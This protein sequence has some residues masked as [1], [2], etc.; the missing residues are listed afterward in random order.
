MRG[1]A[2]YVASALV[3]LSS[4]V[5]AVWAG[6][7]R[8][9]AALPPSLADRAGVI[10]PNDAALS[11]M[12]NERE[13]AARLVDFAS[14]ARFEMPHADETKRTL[15]A[16][17]RKHGL[18][19]SDL[20]SGVRSFVANVALRRTAHEAQWA[21]PT[22]KDGTPWIPDVRVW[23]MNEGSFDQ[24]EAF[25]SP[26]PGSISMRV[27]VPQGASLTFAEGT[28]NATSQAT[29]FIV[30]VLDGRGTLHEVY[31]HG[32]EP[33]EARTW[34]DASVDLR[35]FVGEEIELRLITE[36]TAP[37]SQHRERHGAKDDEPRERD[38]AGP[39]NGRPAVDARVIRE[40]ALTTPSSA[41]ALWGN[42]T[43]F[44]QARPS[45]PYNVLWI[46]VDALRADVVAGLHDDVDD[47]RKRAAPHPPLE[48]LLPKVEG[49]TPEI[50]ALVTRGVRFTNA[51]SA[52]SWTR[53]GTLALLSGARSSELG[54]DA[55]S[56]LLKPSEV[57]RFYASSPPLLPLLLRRHGVV[58]RAF[59]NNYFLAG[60][61]PIG[62]DF[63]FERVVDH[64]YRTRDTLEITRDAVAWIR[65]NRASRFFAFVNYNSPHEPYEP[66]ARFLA[67]VPPPPVGPVDSM[68]RLYMAEAAK[69]DEAIGLLMRALEEAELRETTIVVV[70]ADHGETM[71]SAH[72]G[73]SGLDNTPIRYHH[74]ASN[75]EETTKIPIVIVAP[76][77][78]PSGVSVRARVRSTDIAPT[79]LELMKLETPPS[80]S[81]RSLASLARG[82]AEPSER[83]IVSEGRA[84]RAITFG[85]WRLIV[86]EGLG[87]LLIEGGKRREIDTELFD[88]E[89]DPGERTDVSSKHP[90]VV[91]EMKG[92]LAA[93]L[94][95]APLAGPN[96]RKDIAPPS[97]SAPYPRI[98]LRFAG[99]GSS[100]R[101]S[102]TFH[103]GTDAQRALS[104]NVAPVELPSDA[105]RRNGH[106]FEL[107]FRTEKD[108]A[109]GVDM[110][111]EPSSTP[112]TWTLWLDD[113][114]W[115]RGRVYG[116]P[117]GL[118][119]DALYT[120]VA[121]EA[122]R[123]AA[124][125]PSLAIL[126]PGRD[127]GVFVT[128][129][130]S[131]GAVE[132][133]P[134]GSEGADEMARLLR[135]WGYAHGTSG[136]P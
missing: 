118:P 42:P 50:D 93:A 76:S 19:F 57:D 124:Q 38:Q 45:V 114:P 8:E 108:K 36:A 4:I 129:D 105:I 14:R 99:A 131:N 74:S 49:L 22:G 109:V 56:W 98:R 26:G 51:Y 77:A 100:R 58:T 96:R 115:P 101:V 111:V 73:T 17:W 130:P 68:A 119:F 48:A 125:A 71:S 80:M 13:V 12:A 63:G 117:Y 107:A 33:D 132:A 94:A 44:R 40:E 31:R 88:L 52:G 92:R 7:S 9:Q 84:S 28:L 103:V 62:L 55:T 97:A 59:V 126:E 86:R 110:T 127:L 83:V 43:I 90:E 81:G 25:V 11:T 46:V 78:L 89:T 47:A 64:R 136:K 23:N 61:A 133:H 102:G 106:S 37:S 6:R 2:S 112:V 18:V 87:R 1:L 67:R 3:L 95:N 30:R 113:A 54:I 35:A 122:A 29:V 85:R 10:A 82:E 116:G 123:R 39:G 120:G 15:D 32:L 53:P 91:E 121:T 72:V 79:L 104:W 134:S 21:V 60:Y 20:P 69:D 66:P 41:V 34:Q 65:E 24:R 70:T 27:T 135:E 128:L 16:H 75:F 5:L